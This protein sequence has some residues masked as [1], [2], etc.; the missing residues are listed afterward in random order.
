MTSKRLDIDQVLRALRFAG[1]R[2]RCHEDPSRWVATCIGCRQADALIIGES[3]HG[4][5]A[6]LGCRYRCM[7]PVELAALLQVDPALLAERAAVAEATKWKGIAYRLADGWQ[8]YL[9]TADAHEGQLEV[10]A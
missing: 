4:S 10:A 5:T 1:L 9:A 8:R 7:Q 2:Y 6:S 3:E